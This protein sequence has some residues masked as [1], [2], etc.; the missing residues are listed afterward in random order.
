MAVLLQRIIPLAA[1]TCERLKVHCV[2]HKLS[3]VYIGGE[4]L[5]LI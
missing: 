1:G 2:T 5:Y 3:A 4:M